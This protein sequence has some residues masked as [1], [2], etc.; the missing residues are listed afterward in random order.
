[1]VYGINI[2][3]PAQQFF[4]FLVS[5]LQQVEPKLIFAFLVGFLGSVGYVTALHFKFVGGADK[6]REIIIK[7]FYSSSSFLTFFKHFWYCL[8]GGLIALIFQ[9][10]VPNFVGIQSLILGATWPAI[11]SQFLSGR[12]V[13]LS[14]EERGATD[15]G[16]NENPQTKG[17]IEK[18]S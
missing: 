14:D 9:I 3:T 2:L 10:D 15:F 7:P 8:I 16:S 11:V 17:A 5:L 4:C 18:L 13:S 1:M 12:L 6:N